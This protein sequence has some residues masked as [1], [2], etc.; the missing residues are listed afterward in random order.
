MDNPTIVA[1]VILVGVFLLIGISIIKGGVEAAI[2]LWSVMGA[3]TGVAFGAITSFYFTNKLNQHEI[4]QANLQKETAVLALN[5][6]ALK[7]AEANKFVTPF[8]MVLKGELKPS[9]SFPFS[10]KLLSSIPDQERAELT[11]KVENAAAQLK[12]IHE[13]KQAIYQENKPLEKK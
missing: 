8:A 13:M 4:Q 9:A 5:N 1:V 10:A 12:D 7:A 3:L 2:K 6:A 11:T